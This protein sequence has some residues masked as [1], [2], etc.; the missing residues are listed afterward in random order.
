MR[1]QTPAPVIA[2]VTETFSQRTTHGLLDNFFMHAGA[3]GAPPEGSK[4][5]MAQ[6]WL[7]QIN[8]DEQFSQ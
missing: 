4:R 6:E 3:P 8:R 2:A 7:R 1:T 5:V